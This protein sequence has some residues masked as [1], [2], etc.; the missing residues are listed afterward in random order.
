MSGSSVVAAFVATFLGVAV[1]LAAP[2]TAAN[3]VPDAP[4]I[5]TVAGGAASGQLAVNYT[6]PASDGGAAITGYEVS[7]DDGTIWFPCSG[8][9]GACPLL[10]LVNGRLYTVVLRA[11]SAAGPGQTSA[12][13]SGTPSLPLGTDPDKPVTLPRPSVRVGATFN[14]ASNSLGV[15]G[16]ITKLGVGTLPKLRFTRAIPDKAAAERHLAVTATSNLTGV[17]ISIPGSW[18]W[19]DDRSAI[20][21]PTTFWPGN[22]TITIT[23]SLDG[24]VMGRS[25][26]NYVVGAKSLG[27]S[28]V[29]QTARSLIARVDGA[30]RMMKVYVDGDR[31]HTFPISLGKSG[32]ETRNGVKVVSTLKEPKHTYT[33]VALDIDPNVEEPYELKDIPWNTRLTPTGEFMHAAPWALSRLG[34]W[35]GSHGCT[36]MRPEDAK[37]IYDVTI[38]GD[39]VLYTRTGGLTVEPGNG[40][41]GLWNIPA[42]QWLAKSALVSVT[43]SVDTSRITGPSSNLPAATA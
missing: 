24:V 12:P 33:S 13:A 31:V 19:V 34:K 29:F 39:V 8:T 15:D 5:T 37:W 43:G 6:A 32:W 36:N 9:V 11:T 25:G 22:S 16:T 38:P 21:R 20:F 28:Y 40:P 14:A 2:A 26:A 42:S 17:T 4:L 27:T 30:T 3:G 23:S 35:N 18:G 10:N 7:L 41:G 1:A